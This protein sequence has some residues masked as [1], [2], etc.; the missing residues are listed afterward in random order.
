MLIMTYSGESKSLFSFENKQ[1]AV[2]KQFYLGVMRW[3]LTN[4]NLLL[5]M[6][7]INTV[8]FIS[9]PFFDSKII[10]IMIRDKKIK[11]NQKEIYRLI[12]KTDDMS[13]RSI[14]Q[15][16]TIYSYICHALSFG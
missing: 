13:N 5:D 8:E 4:K 7:I 14:G 2:S 6:F 1:F 11:P 10:S 3:I 16:Q 9:P 12:S 15:L